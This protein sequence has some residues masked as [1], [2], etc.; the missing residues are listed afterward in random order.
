V[1]AICAVD[2]L[3]R[4]AFVIGSPRPERLPGSKVGAMIRAYLF[5]V[6]SL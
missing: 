1:R 5:S 3:D 2:L 4:S 6:K